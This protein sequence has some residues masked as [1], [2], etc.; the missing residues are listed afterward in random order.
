M[1]RSPRV[2]TV[3][4]SAL[5]VLVAG[6][7][8][9]AA[10]HWKPNEYK[11]PARYKYKVTSYD[12]D[13]KNEVVYILDIQ[14][15]GQKNADGQPLL[16]V[17]TTTETLTTQDDLTSSGY[18]GFSPAQAWAPLVASSAMYIAWMGQLDLEVGEKMSF[19]GVGKAKV[20]AKETVAGVE[21]YACE[22]SMKDGDEEKK[23]AD[24][25]V[26]P[27][28]P[29]ALRSRTYSDGKVQFEMELLEYQKH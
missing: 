28:L 13:Q 1:V 8:A 18:L 12:G 7:I 14:A 17:S 15:T 21:G 11:G 16:R 5:A 3:V 2:R 24:L 23:V 6:G 25:V 9:L 10:D 22:I 19:F 4:L 27:D 20:L 26:S 29:L